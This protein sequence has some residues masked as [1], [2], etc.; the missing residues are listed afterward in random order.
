MRRARRRRSQNRLILH[1]T[2]CGAR[3]LLI[4]GPA[5]GEQILAVDTTSA[6]VM[7]MSPAGGIDMVRTPPNACQFAATG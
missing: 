7:A 5:V 6:A 3:T 1:A 4:R 2:P